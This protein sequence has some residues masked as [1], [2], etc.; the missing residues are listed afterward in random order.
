[1]KPSNI[2]V[3]DHRK[4]TVRESSA[5]SDI[6]GTRST[7]TNLIHGSRVSILLI[8]HHLKVSGMVDAQNKKRATRRVKSGSTREETLDPENWDEIR[9]L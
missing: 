2:M 6:R 5:Y 7:A 9:Y 1:M 4:A 3:A 8:V